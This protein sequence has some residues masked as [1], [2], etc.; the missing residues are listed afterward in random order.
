[1]KVADKILI[2]DDACPMCA[3][4][5]KLF[6]ENGLIET[7]GRQSFSIVDKVILAQ[8]DKDRCRNEIPL[9]NTVNNTVI[10]GID[11]M[12]EILGARFPFIKIIGTISPVNW[13]L[14]KLYNLISYNRRVVTAS[15]ITGNNFDCTPDFNLRYRILFLFLGFCFNTLMLIPEYHYVFLN[16]FFSKANM[17]ELQVSHLMLVMVNFI[18]PVKL[19]F[20]QAIE[21]LGQVNMTA[22]IY[23][24]LLIPL[25]LFN[26]LFEVP[27]FFNNVYLLI[28]LC[29]VI[30]TYKKR[31]QFAGILSHRYIIILDAIASALFVSFLAFNK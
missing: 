24:L 4:Y 28:V 20:K 18:L 5:T 6:V 14:K 9:I 31:M 22:L 17:A 1:M 21:F 8:I 29:I 19:S 26:K 13:I 3:G 12:L 11:A 2:Y 30:R 27:G 16:S 25:I 7:N 15:N 10:Y 23:S